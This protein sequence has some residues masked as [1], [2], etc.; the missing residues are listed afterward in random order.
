[1][2]G[3]SL[4]GETVRSPWYQSFPI[5]RK[6]SALLESRGNQTRGEHCFDAGKRKSD[7]GLLDKWKFAESAGASAAMCRGV[8]NRGVAR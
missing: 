3:R 5:S 4:G 6:M 2:A 8:M 1:V 7:M